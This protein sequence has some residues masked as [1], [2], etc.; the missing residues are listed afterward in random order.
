MYHIQLFSVQPKE[1]IT[2]TKDEDDIYK[3]FIMRMFLLYMSNFVLK[4]LPAG[5]GIY[6]NVAVPENILQK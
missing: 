3:E 1:R 5:C 4:Y 2:P 6:I